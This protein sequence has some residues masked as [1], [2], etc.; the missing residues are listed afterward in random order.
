MTSE[1][2]STNSSQSGTVI[3]PVRLYA[4]YD[5]DTDPL[6]QEGLSSILSGI[7]SAEDPVSDDEKADILR[8]SRI[9][10]FA[11]LTGH[12]ISAEDAARIDGSRTNAHPTNS[13]LSAV[14]ADAPP[15]MVGEGTRILSFDELRELILHGKTDQI[16][17]NKDIPDKLSDA[18]PS[19]S[20]VAP[21]KKPW[22]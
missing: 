3:D 17:N 7:E 10:Y 14:A 16:P 8:R 12:M 20:M 15:P 21:P 9:F 18:P 5:F 11:R 13:S 4:D 2:V 19:E 6:Y 22:E 1:A